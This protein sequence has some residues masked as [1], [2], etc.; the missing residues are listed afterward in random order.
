MLYKYRGISNFRYFTDI[1]LK[2]RLYAARYFEMNDP[3]EGRYLYRGT[4]NMDDDI[5]RILAGEKEK[6]RVVSLSRNPAN[7]LM[8]AHYAE[9]HKGVAF[10]IEPASDQ[11]HEIRPIHYDGIA[12]FTPDSPIRMSAIDI[13]SHKLEV[14]QY[15]E[16]ERIFVKGP[17]YATVRVRELILGRRM[18][19]QDVG[20]IKDLVVRVNPSIVI[21][22]AD[23][24]LAQ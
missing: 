14:W 21:R 8:W 3:M 7:E 22:H 12:N 10:G 4:H 15:E 13:L 11:R 20:F 19:K 2:S 23:E 16:E 1:V 6:L 24:I 17:M 9:G 5:R 18:S